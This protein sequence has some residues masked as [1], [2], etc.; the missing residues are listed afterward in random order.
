MVA[1][2]RKAAERRSQPRR[3]RGE[4]GRPRP[5]IW[6]PSWDCFLRQPQP[7]KGPAMQRRQAKLPERDDRCRSQEAQPRVD[8]QR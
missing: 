4:G 3:G 2:Y 7:R 1:Q 8:C 5:V 6:Q